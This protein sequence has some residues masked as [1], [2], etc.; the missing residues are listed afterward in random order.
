MDKYKIC[1]VDEI[2]PGDHKIVS[3][4]GREI[5]IFNVKGSYYALR[6]ICPHRGAK[7]CTGTLDGTTLPSKPGVYSWGKEG[8]ILRCP[9]HGWEF[10]VCTGVSLFDPKIRVKTYRV[11]VQEEQL[12]LIT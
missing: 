10:D 1:I 3:V 12:V 5:G 11:E 4:N 9:W 7:L 8:E 2:P 6:N